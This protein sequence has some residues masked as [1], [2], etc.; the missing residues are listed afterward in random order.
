MTSVNN[1]VSNSC[2]IIK[3]PSIR[4][5]GT[6]QLIYLKV[7]DFRFGITFTYLGNAT[8]P[9]SIAYRMT[10]SAVKSLRYKK[11]SSSIVCGSVCF[12]YSISNNE[13]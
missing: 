5:N 11:N 2:T 3:G 1:V 13:N 8:D 9:S 10:S 4:I 12:K 7:I 6:L